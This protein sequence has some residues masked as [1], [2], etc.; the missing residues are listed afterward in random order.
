[1][2]FDQEWASMPGVMPVASGGIHAG[3]MHQLLHYLGEDV[4][5]QFGGG[6]IG[7]P[8][9]IAAGATANR[10]AVEAMIQARNEGKDYFQE[11]PDILEKAAKG[12]PELDAALQV[13]KDITLNFESTDMPDVQLWPSVGYEERKQSIRLTQGSFLSLPDVAAEQI[14]S[15]RRYALRH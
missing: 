8:M 10:V 2:F 6:T 13:W 12:C 4:V 11:G 9:G 7:H 1:I 15:R 14:E 5:L 3:Q